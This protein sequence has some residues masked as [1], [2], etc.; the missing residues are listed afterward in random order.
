MDSGVAFLAAGLWLLSCTSLHFAPPLVS[1]WLSAVWRR[2]GGVQCVCRVVRWEWSKTVNLWAGLQTGNKMFFQ[3][4]A[5]CNS[6]CEG[7][8]NKKNET[9]EIIRGWGKSRTRPLIG[10]LNQGL[11][12][13]AGTA[14]KRS[15]LMNLFYLLVFI[16]DHIWSIK[17]ILLW[18]KKFMDES[19]P[20]L[21]SDEWA[22]IY[23]H[24]LHTDLFVFLSTEVWYNPNPKKT[25]LVYQLKMKKMVDIRLI[26]NQCDLEQLIDFFQVWILKY[27]G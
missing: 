18:P 13:T 16:T 19:Q 11:V 1:L 25:A 17:M 14:V 27:R 6:C 12:V 5:V 15:L 21:A 9:E 26:D 20:Q 7:V 4:G 3:K 2:A 23:F 10:T 8:L 24:I 22:A